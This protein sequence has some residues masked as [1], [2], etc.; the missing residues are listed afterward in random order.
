[1]IDLARSSFSTRAYAAPVAAAVVGLLVVTAVI[2]AGAL[3]PG[4]WA[5]TLSGAAPVIILAMAQAFAVLAGRAGIDLSVG[6]LA[7]L[8]NAVIVVYVVGRGITSPVVVV[9]VAVLV[10]LVSGILNGFLVAYMRIPAV[11][12]TLGTY[13]A[14]LGLTLEIL[15]TPGGAAPLWLAQLAGMVGPVPGMLLVIAGV[16]LAWYLLSRTAFRRNLFAVGS[17]ERSAYAS[18]LDVVRIR[19][20]AYCMTGVVASIGGLALTGILQSG[21]P[22]VSSIYTLQSIA[23]VALGGVALTGGRG[24]LLGAALGGSLM[25]LVQ[26]LL[27]LAHVGLN[28]LQIAYGAILLIAIALNSVSA[29]LRRRSKESAALPSAAAA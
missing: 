26:N 17:D 11:V 7:G 24:G 3:A 18:G 6:P 4:S 28:G 19:F 29:L 20:L 13:L 16:L 21:D 14:Y 8:V 15:P 25:F 10:G 22:N 5:A 1:M 12:A 2:D 9:G 27:S 23:A